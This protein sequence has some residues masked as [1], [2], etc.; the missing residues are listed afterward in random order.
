MQRS[1]RELISQQL[2]AT[3]DHD[4]QHPYKSSRWP[5]RRHIYDLGYK[6]DP[7]NFPG[8]LV[9]AEGDPEYQDDRAAEK[10]YEHMGIV[11]KFFDEAFGERN[12]FKNKRPPVGIVH[13]G[14][15]FPG[16]WFHLPFDGDSDHQAIICGDGWDHQDE[17]ASESDT[18][19]HKLYSRLFGN[20]SG[21]LEVVAH[22]MV[23]GF[24]HA[25]CSLD[26][27]GEPGTV[28]EHLADVFGIM[29]EQ[30]HTGQSVFD[31]D[32]LVGED[33]FLPGTS[34]I[35]LRSFKSPGEA[36]SFETSSTLRD[37]QVK[38]MDC[39]Y[40]GEKDGGGVHINSGILNHAF[41]LVAT[42]LGK[43]EPYS[44]KKAG[45]IW[46]LACLH[47]MMTSE[48]SMKRWADLTLDT[49]KRKSFGAE[50]MRIVWEAWDSV[51]IKLKKPVEI[52]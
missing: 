3:N 16:A 52:S 44:W 11:Y 49:A 32:W 2:H 22:E 47:P 19:S 17:M 46:Y 7:F 25:L 24:L 18:P 29:C 33:L 23:H 50:V 20:F 35:A 27:Q 40:K 12:M 51:G 6:K 4:S 10:L 21:S 45:R 48:C 36:Y 28:N 8:D 31:A 5:H 15:H 43:L 26:T 37:P 13:Y 42:N 38:H 41:Y 39:L 34:G 30:Y 14:Q 9:K 1:E